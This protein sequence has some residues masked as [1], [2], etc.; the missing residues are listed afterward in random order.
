[1]RGKKQKGD[2]LRQVDAFLKERY[3][4]A[5]CALEYDGDAWRLLVMGR[6]SAQCTD[7]KVNI[8]CKELFTKYPTF[9]DMA[10]AKV[11]DVEKIIKPCGLYKMKAKNR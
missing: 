10:E 4:N 2:L 8:V 7:A 9:H 3:P 6:L 1:M 11:E 5:E